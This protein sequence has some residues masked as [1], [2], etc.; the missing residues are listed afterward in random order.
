[1]KHLLSIE[2]L[3]RAEIQKLLG[4]TISI[5]KQRGPQG[6]KPLASQVWALLFS[7]SSTRTRVSFEV[8]IRGLGGQVIFL[9]ASEIQLGRGEPIKDTARVLGR[10]VQGAVFRTYAQSDVEEFAAFAGIPTINA[11]TDE[12]Q[13][14]RASCRERV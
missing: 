10:M 8:G 3:S 2:K 11:L 9:S 14:G 1:M 6:P 7:K 4:D 12:E 5:K 13:I